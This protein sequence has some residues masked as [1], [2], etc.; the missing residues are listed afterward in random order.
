[1]Q[2][3]LIVQPDDNNAPATSVVA[4]VFAHLRT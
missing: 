3:L 4:A 1:M 2:F